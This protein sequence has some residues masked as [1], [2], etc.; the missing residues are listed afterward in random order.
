MALR[1]LKRRDSG[2]RTRPIGLDRDGLRYWLL[3]VRYYRPHPLQSGRGLCPTR[4][5]CITT[6]KKMH[7]TLDKNL[8][9]QLAGFPQSSAE[10]KGT[11]SHLDKFASCLAWSICPEIN[12]GIQKNSSIRPA[13]SLNLILSPAQ[14]ISVDFDVCV[15][16]ACVQV[17]SL[18]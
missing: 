18:N 11:A 7:T 10:H 9:A 1:T 8:N 12:N 3:Q 14:L 6:Q 2:M 16:M 13:Q 17:S 5:F 15:S 4:M